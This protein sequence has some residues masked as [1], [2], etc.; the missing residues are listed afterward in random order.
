MVNRNNT[1]K[2]NEMK[3]CTCDTINKQRDPECVIHKKKRICEMCGKSVLEGKGI[4][5]ET[6]FIIGNTNMHQNCFDSMWSEYMNL[7]Y[8]N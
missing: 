1:K 4:R 7:D 8:K 5:I 3:K 2:E 6:D